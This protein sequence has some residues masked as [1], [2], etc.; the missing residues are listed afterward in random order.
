MP[1]SPRAAVLV[2]QAVAPPVVAD[3]P[4][5]AA[6][7]EAE[8]IKI[9]TEKQSAATNEAADEEV[10]RRDQVLLMKSRLAAPRPN[11]WGLE[12]PLE[13]DPDPTPGKKKIEPQN[14]EL[15]HAAVVVAVAAIEMTKIAL[16][17]T[18]PE[19]VVV[20]AIVLE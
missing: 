2:D 8:E 7:R 13:E 11:P 9:K 15:D 4:L 16:P 10:R 5:V 14:K 6:E 12:L 1:I 17:R 19:A 18:E 20:A 3:P